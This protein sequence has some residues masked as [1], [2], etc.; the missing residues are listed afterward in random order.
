M[1]YKEISEKLFFQFSARLNQKRPYIVAIDGLSGAGKTTIVKSLE[2]E[3]SNR[4]CKAVTIHIDDYIVERDK[5]YNTGFEEWYE[6]YYLQWNIESLTRHLF[7][8]LLHNHHDLQLPFYDHSTDSLRM[9]ALSIPASS[10]VLIEGIFLQRR[11]WRGFYDYVIYLNCP[12]EVRYERV[13]KRD[14]YIGDIQ[15]R[16]NKYNKRYWPGEK[17]Y[18]E[19]ENPIEQADVVIDNL[20]TN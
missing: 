6:Y 17:H 15:Q 12:R 14:S 19:V 7:E 11:E 5:R 4:N 9:R 20:N 18:L 3:I 2:R 16:L 1:T 13:L 8:G 10:I